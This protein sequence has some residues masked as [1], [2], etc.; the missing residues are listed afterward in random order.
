MYNIYLAVKRII[1][2]RHTIICSSNHN[3]YTVF[4]SRMGLP[5]NGSLAEIPQE[6]NHFKPTGNSCKKKIN[7]MLCV[8]SSFL[9]MVNSV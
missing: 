1:N 4:D 6:L 9:L 2:A 8:L 7:V 3:E 5:L